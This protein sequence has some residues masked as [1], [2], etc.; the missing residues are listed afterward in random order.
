MPLYLVSKIGF[1]ANFGLGIFCLQKIPPSRV[2]APS[3]AHYAAVSEM[4]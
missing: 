2:T 1:L 4:H 3:V